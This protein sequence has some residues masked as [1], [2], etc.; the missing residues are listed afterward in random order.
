MKKEKELLKMGENGWVI[1][2]FVLPFFTAIAVSL[3]GW[4]ALLWAGLPLMFLSVES[5]F[6]R[7]IIWSY[8]R[9]EKLNILDEK[10]NGIWLYLLLVGI[11]CCLLKLVFKVIPDVV[12]NPRID[13]GLTFAWILL[14]IL[15]LVALGFV[16]FAIYSVIQWW[17]NDNKEKAEELLGKNKVK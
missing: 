17:I 11:Y 12:T 8:N 5:Y 1:L 16:I 10:G 4:W 14:G 6:R 9:K 15:G 2:S 7:T 13:W 3:F